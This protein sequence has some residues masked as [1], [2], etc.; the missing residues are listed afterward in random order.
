MQAVRRKES[1]GVCLRG[2]PLAARSRPGRPSPA[3]ISSTRG[4]RAPP[5]SPPFAPPSRASPAG[6]RKKRARTMAEPHT[7]WPTPASAKGIS[8]SSSAGRESGPSGGGPKLNSSVAPVRKSSRGH[9]SSSATDERATPRHG[10]CSSVA[11]STSSFWTSP[12][13]PRGETQSYSSY[14]VRRHGPA[15][16]RALAA[17]ALAA[18]SPVLMTWRKGTLALANALAGNSRS[19]CVK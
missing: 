11:R 18:V 1:R 15:R 19:A 6:Q 9:S 8:S 10:C 16:G 13:A 3:P 4:L 12:S 14:I 17:A 5:P 2:A 7:V